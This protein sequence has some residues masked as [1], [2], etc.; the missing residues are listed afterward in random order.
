[1]ERYFGIGFVILCLGMFIFLIIGVSAIFRYIVHMT[2]KE[3][4]VA[5]SNNNSKLNNDE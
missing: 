5:P 1:M 2:K 3:L 4:E